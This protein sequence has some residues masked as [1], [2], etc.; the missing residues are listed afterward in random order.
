[1]GKVAE[2]VI[3]TAY[4]SQT[5]CQRG[6]RQEKNRSN[7]RFPA[8]CRQSDKPDYRFDTYRAQRPCEPVGHCRFTNRDYYSVS[9]LE[10]GRDNKPPDSGA[11]AEE[12]GAG[13]VPS[14][15]EIEQQ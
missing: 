14:Y 1:K 7:P 9:A 2:I 5:E 10:L 15:P 6:C 8:P 4:L 3:N 12:Q 11:E 13:P